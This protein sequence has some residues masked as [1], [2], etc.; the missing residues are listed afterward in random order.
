MTDFF[1]EQYEHW[2][3]R[4]CRYA[5]FVGAV[6]GNCE[7]VADGNSTAEEAIARI[8]ALLATVTDPATG[9]LLNSRTAL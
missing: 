1:L 5:E 4:A 2:F 9:E 3:Q 7:L 8:R 6:Q